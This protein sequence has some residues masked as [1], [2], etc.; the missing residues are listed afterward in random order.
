[1]KA[2]PGYTWSAI[3]APDN[4]SLVTS[5]NDGLIKFWNLDTLKVALTLT[6]S[7]GPGVFL[8]FSRDGNLLASMDA[9]GTVKLWPAAPIAEIPKK[10]T[11]DTNGG[12]E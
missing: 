12:A 8:T 1:M 6:H 2:H 4:K 7:H 11:A 5:G 3:F 10:K 9:H